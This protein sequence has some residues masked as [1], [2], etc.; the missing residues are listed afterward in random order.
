MC[1]YQHQQS[2]YAHRQTHLVSKVAQMLTITCY[3]D[4]ESE[5]VYISLEFSFRRYQVGKKMEDGDFLSIFRR[6][7]CNTK[8]C[9]SNTIG[10]RWYIN[11][12]NI[13]YRSV[14]LPED[15]I[16][17]NGNGERKREKKMIIKTTFSNS[18]GAENNETI[19][20]IDAWQNVLLMRWMGWMDG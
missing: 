8:K 14:G 5:H 4:V 18:N 3:R 19:H 9:C 13:R 10:L 20:N 7:I 17:I 6:S 2:T 16:S 15:N 12:R 11:I 1:M